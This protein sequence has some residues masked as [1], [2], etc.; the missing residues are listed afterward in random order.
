MTSITLNSGGWRYD[1]LGKI[2]ITYKSIYVLT[3]T[4]KGYVQILVPRHPNRKKGYVLLHRFVM[5][6]F[7]GR[8]LEPEEVVHHIDGNKQNNNIKNLMLFK[9][10]GEHTKHHAKLKNMGMASIELVSA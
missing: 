7:I 6:K 4:Q 9:N 3:K 8:Y 10:G 1:R 5:E 2:V